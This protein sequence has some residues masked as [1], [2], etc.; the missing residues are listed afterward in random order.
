MF[1]FYFLI[2]TVSLLLLLL[3]NSTARAHKAPRRSTLTAVSVTGKGQMAIIM[4]CSSIVLIITGGHRKGSARKRF[5]LSARI[6]VHSADKTTSMKLCTI[7]TECLLASWRTWHSQSCDFG[8]LSREN[9]AQ[10]ENAPINHFE[11]ASHFVRLRDLRDWIQIEIRIS[12]KVSARVSN[13]N[14]VVT[15]DRESN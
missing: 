9:S 7:K 10:V 2:V 3:G 12:N 8:S 15:A 11:G 5:R 6:A 1:R 13:A 14:F 4:L